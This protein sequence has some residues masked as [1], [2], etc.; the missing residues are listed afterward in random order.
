MKK[1]MEGKALTKEEIYAII[2]DIVEGN[3]SQ[4]EIAAF[5][6]AQKYLGMSLDE[7][8]Y[9]SRAMADTGEKIEFDEMVFDKHSIGG[10]PGNKVSLLIVPIV[11]AAGLLIPKTSSRAITSPSGTADTMEVLAPV[12]FEAAELKKIAKIKFCYFYKQYF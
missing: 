5:A 11:A 2:K 6:I 9:L 4:L 12:E 3:L 8:E 10:V 1:K 7:I